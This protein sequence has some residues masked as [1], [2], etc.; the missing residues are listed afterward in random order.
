VRCSRLCSQE[1]DSSKYWKSAATRVCRCIAC[2]QEDTS[3]LIN[4]CLYCCCLLLLSCLQEND[5][6]KYWEFSR[7]NHELSKGVTLRGML[8]FK[9][10]PGG[11]IPLE[12]V[13][14]I[15]CGQL[16]VIT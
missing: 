15:V 10:A 6:A 11:A 3:P 14:A 9:K 1:N 4:H 16:L 8:R 5:T 12:E 2:L 13:G 7:L